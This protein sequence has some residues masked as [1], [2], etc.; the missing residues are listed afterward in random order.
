M[1]NSNNLVINNLHKNSRPSDSS[2]PNIKSKF[3]V[4]K[5]AFRLPIFACF[6]DKQSS[7]LIQKYSENRKQIMNYYSNRDFLDVTLNQLIDNNS[8]SRN[9]GKDFKKI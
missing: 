3:K 7:K 6:D 1:N 9:E 4:N 2:D 5:Q 8:S